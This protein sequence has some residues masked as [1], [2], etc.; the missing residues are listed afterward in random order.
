MLAH[1][2][3]FEL[4]SS[5]DR[6]RCQSQRWELYRLRP[7]HRRCLRLQRIPIAK[8]NSRSRSSRSLESWSSTFA[9]LDSWD[10]R[11]A[12]PRC[13]PVRIPMLLRHRS[14]L[15]LLLMKTRVRSQHYQ[16]TP[17]LLDL[18]RCQAPAR[19]QQSRPAA[20]RHRSSRR[21]W[22]IRCSSRCA[23]PMLRDT[24]A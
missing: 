13:P 17:S 6:H 7:T 3:T 12:M 11:R 18:P 24:W 14:M 9:R 19:C 8:S 16:A 22:C 23:S 2:L 5:L 15:L 10:D 4:E 20:S 1:R 21:R